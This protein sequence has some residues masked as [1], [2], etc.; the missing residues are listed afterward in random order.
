[1]IDRWKTRH[2][3]GVWNPSYAADAMGATISL[4]LDNVRSFRASGSDEDDVYVWWGKVKSPNRQQKL[5]HLE[6]IIAIDASLSE[7]ADDSA[8]VHLY[9]TDY[10][11]L[12][13]G[14][15]GQ[16]VRDGDLARN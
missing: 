10:R 6:D 11:S 8:E 13:V 14:H 3:V 9:L 1:M 7:D 12:Y 5:E 16:I 15:V 4:L 2:L